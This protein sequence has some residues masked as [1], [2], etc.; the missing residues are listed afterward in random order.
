MVLHCCWCQAHCQD[1]TDLLPGVYALAQCWVQ[2]GILGGFRQVAAAVDG[3]QE[4]QQ[5]QAGEL[6][7]APWFDS[8]RVRL[9]ILVSAM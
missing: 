8:L 4:Q 5:Q 6:D 7:L 1:R 2:Q 9:L 3:G